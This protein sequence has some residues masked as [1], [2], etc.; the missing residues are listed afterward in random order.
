MFAVRSM[1]A[2]TC[3]AAVPGYRFAHRGYKL[4]QLEI[5]L[6]LPVAHF[7]LIAGDLGLLDAQIV[8][9][10]ILAEAGRKEVV[11]A[12]CRERLFKSFWKK[13]RRHLVGRVGRWSR[14]KLARDAVAPGDDLCGHV[15]I[16]IG[17]R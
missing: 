3:G 1:S 17:G 15:E 5:F 8:V 10:E 6:L 9:D 12:Q 7:G 14:L 11:R 2:A 4:E 13:L 16:R